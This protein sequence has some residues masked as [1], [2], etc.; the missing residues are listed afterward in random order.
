[1]AAVL[2]AVDFEADVRHLAAAPYAEI[3]F[4]ASDCDASV[5]IAFAGAIT[6]KVQSVFLLHEKPCHY[7]RRIGFRFGRVAHYILRRCIVNQEK[8]IQV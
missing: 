4:H 7:S 2:A 6:L 5:F 3:L 8:D 1:M